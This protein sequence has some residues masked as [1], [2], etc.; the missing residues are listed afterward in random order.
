[1]RHIIKIKEWYYFKRRIPKRY[2]KYYEST[3]VLQVSLK[4]TNESVAIQRASV[5]REELENLWDMLAREIP[6]DKN[7]HYH[8]AVSTAQTYNFNYRPASQLANCDLEKIISRIQALK[9]EV[10]ET[11]ETVSALLGGNDIPVFPISEAL[12]QYFEF[13]RPNQT[14]KTADQLRKWRNPRIKAVNNFIKVCRDISVDQLTRNDI[15][16]FRSWWFDRVESE[17]LS[18]NS[19]NK[20]FTHLRTLFHF[21]KD[22]RSLAIS[23]E[24]LFSRVRFKEIKSKRPPF[25]TDYIQNTLLNPNNLKGLDRECQLF[26]CA[27]ADLGARP[28]EIVGLNFSNGD[29]RLDTD[30]PYIYIREEKDKE[31]K[32]PYSKRMLP[33]VGASLYAFQQLP[34]GFKHYYRKSDQLSGNL[35][36]FLRNNDLFPTEEHSVYS[37][38]HSFE[39]RLTAVEPPDKVQAALMGHKYDRPRYGDGPSLEQKLK[40]MQKIAFNIN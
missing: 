28:S 2:K 34:E 14:R 20:D 16:N 31:I 35:N 30:I 23:V 29:I 10:P 9:S 19:P 7:Q 3:V 25:K 36:K 18:P 26:L 39:D 37:L 1:M 22:H 12:E 4:T 17:R 5:L 15:L 27:M 32:T 13:E 40:W 33:L 11:E 6:L 21:A 38:R 24:D 8:T